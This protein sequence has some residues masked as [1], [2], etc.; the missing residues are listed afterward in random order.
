MYLLNDP[1]RVKTI[2]GMMSGVIIGRTISNPAWYDVKT[3]KGVIQNQ[4]EENLK[5]E[6]N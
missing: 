5:S 1:V 3:E 4:P 6:I 2:S